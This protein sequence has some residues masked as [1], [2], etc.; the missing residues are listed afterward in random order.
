MH[1]VGD[2]G[3][4]GLIVLAVL[5]KHTNLFAL[6]PGAAGDKI[7]T[8][9]G[10]SYVNADGTGRNF[11]FPVAIIMDAAGGEAVGV[12][13]CHVPLVVVRVGKGFL[14]Q[15]QGVGLAGFQGQPL[16]KGQPHRFARVGSVGVD[17]LAILNGFQGHATA[18]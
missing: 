16:L 17:W 6:F 1:I 3:D 13:I 12:V 2:G 4:K 10:V 5:T 18:C 11:G 7:H 8:F 9:A 14:C 15:S